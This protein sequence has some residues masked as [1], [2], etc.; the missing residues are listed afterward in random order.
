M[1]LAELMAHAR[2]TSSELAATINMVEV[3]IQADQGQGVMLN[4]ALTR[5]ME[6][7]MWLESAAR[8]ALPADAPADPKI[9]T[10]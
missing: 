6:C 5:L 9:I 3:E 7:T 8:S 10:S 1:T 2:R 4:H